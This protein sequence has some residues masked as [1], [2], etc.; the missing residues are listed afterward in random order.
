MP[1]GDDFESARFLI[2][3]N[4]NSEFAYFYR[5]AR[6]GLPAIRMKVPYILCGYRLTVTYVANPI[7]RYYPSFSFLVDIILYHTYHTVH[8]FTPS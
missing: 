8:T 6:G 4:R 1:K 5:C 2:K 3:E 7:Y